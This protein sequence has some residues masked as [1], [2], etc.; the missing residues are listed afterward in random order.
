M[1]KSFSALIMLGERRRLMLPFGPSYP[2]LAAP[3]F[4]TFPSI[5]V[6]FPRSSSAD[7]VELGQKQKSIVTNTR[8]ISVFRGTEGA[9]EATAVQLLAQALRAKL[10]SKVSP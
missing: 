4:R 5:P 10:L 7:P 8:A 1:H 6:C 3:G 2:K 9:L